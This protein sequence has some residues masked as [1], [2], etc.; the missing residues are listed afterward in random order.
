MNF[1]KYLCLNSVVSITLANYL[2]PK[3]IISH[4]FRGKTEKQR[5]KNAIFNLFSN[6]SFFFFSHA[7]RNFAEI[8]FLGKVL[9]AVVVYE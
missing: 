6:H 2:E 4:L 7:F 1:R 3:I 8:K 5:S 9:F